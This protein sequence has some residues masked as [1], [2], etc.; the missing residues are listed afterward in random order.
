MTMPA[1][2]LDAVSAAIGKAFSREELEAI[3]L[4]ATGNELYE[5]YA[6]T[7]DPLHRAI[8]R[9]LDRLIEKEG[10][11]RWLLVKVLM[12]AVANEQLRLL[13][14]KASP[15]TL[16]A[17]PKVD[18]EVDRVL[19]SL[20]LVMATVLKPE[21]IPVLQPSRDRIAAVSDQIHT[22]AAF[23]N[24]HE[25]LHTLHLKLAFRSAAVGDQDRLK[26][27]QT[28][29]A[30]A[31]IAA[32]PLGSAAEVELAW[33][34]ELERLAT[35]FGTAL[36]TANSPAI[37]EG[38]DNVQRLIRLQL[39]RL[40]TQIFAAADRLSLHE[41]ILVLP[42]VVTLEESF[43]QLSHGISDL[44]ATMMARA[45]VH[46][47]WQDAEN[48]LS[49]IESLLNLPAKSALSLIQQHWLLLRSR[50]SWLTPLDRDP[51]LKQQAE[52]YSK[53]IDTEIFKETPPSSAMKAAFAELYRLLLLHFFKVDA[54]LK[55][56]CTSLGKFD[57]PLNL[58]LKEI[59]N[60]RSF[61][62]PAAHGSG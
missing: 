52:D 42:S 13:I 32:E 9:T 21:F 10:A 40:N 7:D 54:E 29:C 53:R 14:V 15:E 37:E 19:K 2:Y 33:I 5:E 56:D 58:M 27:I 41:L 61:H 6:S 45:L 39:S 57:T 49:L 25:C 59:G 4:A 51:T 43:E 8:R 50:V 30:D 36:A 1:K 22:L 31:R 28:T 11:E 24:L 38:F 18:D 60:A 47:F 35:E 55:K 12:S 34:G 17:P 20:G 44:K 62:T 46:K 48:E 23:K 16:A 26:N 3:V